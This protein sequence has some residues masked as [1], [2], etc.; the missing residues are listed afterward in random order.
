MTAIRE[1]ELKEFLVRNVEPM[2]DSIYGNRYRA[3]ARLID[4]MYLPCVVFQGTRGQ[5]DLALRR[6]KEVSGKKSEY[7][8]M[9]EVFVTGGSRIVNY[10]IKTV[11]LSPFAWPLEILKTINGETTMGWTAFVVEMKDGTMYSY[12]TQ[13]R[14][15]FFDVPTG[16]S[17]GDIQRIH[18][19]MV[20]SAERG[21]EA[22]SVDSYE[23]TVDSYKHITCLREKPF[24]TCFVKEL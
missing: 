13:F 16:Y 11:E 15:E 18:S 19:G 7:E 8:H 20:Y 3:A 22:F 24:F 17:H 1:N 21:L 5:V 2:K 10:D 9:V 6:F 23:G 12:G 4:G 14:F